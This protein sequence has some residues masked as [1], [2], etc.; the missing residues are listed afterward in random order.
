MALA[1]S[2]GVS[3]AILCGKYLSGKLL[4]KGDTKTTK[5]TDETSPD[6]AEDLDHSEMNEAGMEECGCETECS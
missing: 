2:G 4:K 5:E 1:S 3:S 6:S